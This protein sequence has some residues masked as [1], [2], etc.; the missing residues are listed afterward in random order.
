MEAGAVVVVTVVVEAKPEPVVVVA[1]AFR[2]GATVPSPAPQSGPPRWAR[3]SSQGHHR[4]HRRRSASAVCYT[5]DRSNPLR[6]EG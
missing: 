5:P 1:V 6:P 4:S 2:I 3:Q